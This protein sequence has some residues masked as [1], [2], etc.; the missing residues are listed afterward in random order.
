MEP[1]YGMEWLLQLPLERTSVM[2]NQRRIS[3]LVMA[4]SRIVHSPSSMARTNKDAAI[5][6]H[7]LLNL[8]GGGG[9]AVKAESQFKRFRSNSTKKERALASLLLFWDSIDCS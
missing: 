4:M 9:T 1:S 2:S 3:L 7:V 6:L 5:N 8:V